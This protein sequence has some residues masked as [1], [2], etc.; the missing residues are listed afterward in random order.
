MPFLAQAPTVALETHRVEWIILAVR[1]FPR[2]DT[3][4]CWD[5]C[6]MRDGFGGAMVEQE[7]VIGFEQAAAPPAVALRP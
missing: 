2:R 7:G 3:D 4:L 6:W 5:V 1:I